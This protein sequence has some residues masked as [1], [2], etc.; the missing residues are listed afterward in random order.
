MSTSLVMPLVERKTINRIFNL[1]VQINKAEQDVT[2][3]RRELFLELIS[4]LNDKEKKSKNDVK[5]LGKLFDLC[6]KLSLTG[7]LRANY[8]LA[9]FYGGEFGNSIV[10]PDLGKAIK[11]LDSVRDNFFIYPLAVKFCE[12]NGRIKMLFRYACDGISS[13]RADFKNK[14]ELAHYVVKNL[15]KPKSIMENNIKIDLFEQIALKFIRDNASALDI[16]ADDIKYINMF[17]S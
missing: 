3:L 9:K 1:N 15:I 11:Y 13:S 12:K 2:N 14:L 10:T 4:H 5:L 7:D 8:Y 16:N 17:L 6:N